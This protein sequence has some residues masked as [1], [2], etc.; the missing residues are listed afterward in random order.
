MLTNK[1]KYG[2]KAMVH[3]AGLPPGR[4]ALV[5]DIADQNNIPKKFLDAILAELRNAGIVRSKKGRGGG[6]ELARPASEIR[7]GQIVRALDGPLAP[8]R[9][10]SAYYYERC[11]D[12]AVEKECPVHLMM[13]EVRNAM[14]HILDNRSLS[15]LRLMPQ[16]NDRSPARAISA[17]K[18]SRAARTPP[19][20]DAASPKKPASSGR[21]PV[22]AM[23]K[24][25]STKSVAAKRAS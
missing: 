10:A 25:G 21:K 2:L 8:I 15:D 19:A 13:F 23:K 4:P 6:Y 12:C 3:L 11:L 22:A 20:P 14:A 7:I 1:G 9:C 5:A 24:S 16:V 17:D 18:K